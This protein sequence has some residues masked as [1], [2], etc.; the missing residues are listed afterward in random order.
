MVQ[1]TRQIKYTSGYK[2]QLKETAFFVTVMTP[3]NPEGVNS[4]FIKLSSSGLMMI[5]SGYAWDGASGPTFDTKSSMRASLFHDAACQLIREC[6]VDRN[7]WG[8]YIND[9]FRDLCIEDNMMPAR[10][11]IWRVGVAIGAE[12]ATATRNVRP[13]ITAPETIKKVNK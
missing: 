7:L 12:S 11:V 2:Y 5:K 8:T 4:Q 10:A 6:Y 3:L 9:V 1:T 13:I